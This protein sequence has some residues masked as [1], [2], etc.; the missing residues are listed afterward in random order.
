MHKPPFTVLQHSISTRTQWLVPIKQRSNPIVSRVLRYRCSAE[1]PS[2]QCQSRPLQVDMPL[3]NLA[4]CLPPGHP[5]LACGKSTKY[6][7]PASQICADGRTC[8]FQ[9][10][11]IVTRGGKCSGHP[12]N[13]KWRLFDAISDVAFFHSSMIAL[14]VCAPANMIGSRQIFTASKSALAEYVFSKRW[15]TDRAAWNLETNV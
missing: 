7:R 3:A 6:Q 10:I 13:H 14:K 12:P 1:E 2:S 4:A 11:G 8:R 5:E 9:A 15:M